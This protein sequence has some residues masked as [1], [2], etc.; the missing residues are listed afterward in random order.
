MA[1]GSHKGVGLPMIRLRGFGAFLGA[2]AFAS[3]AV[4]QLPM[5]P[6]YRTSPE[7]P[8]P[9]ADKAA[10]AVKDRAS[11]NAAG[12]HGRN[13]PR[14]KPASVEQEPVATAAIPPPLS[15]PASKESAAGPTPSQAIEGAATQSPAAAPEIAPAPPEVKTGREAAAPSG[16]PKKATLQ[17]TRR[18]ARI[19]RQVPAYGT[20]VYYAR[21]PGAY[22]DTARGYGSGAYGPSPHSEGP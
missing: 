17:T 19:K 21:P 13:T 11:P 8:Q 10:P 9:K 2:V 14:S 7:T 5:S 22:P 16:R 20:P 4:A 6:I 18:Q 1:R 3:S 12:R 15:A